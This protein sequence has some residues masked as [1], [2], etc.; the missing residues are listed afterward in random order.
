MTNKTIT[1]KIYEV[2]ISDGKRKERIDSYLANTIEYATRSRIQS[3]IKANF[4]TVNSSVVKANYQINPGDKV[5]LRI[6]CIRYAVLYSF[7]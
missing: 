6:P 4:V 3:L 2:V 7:I 5:L 1:E